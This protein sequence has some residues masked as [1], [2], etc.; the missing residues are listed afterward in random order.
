M[1][2]TISFFHS[3]RGKLILLLLAVSLIPLIIF[4]WISY[5]LARNALEQE[6]FN[7][8]IAVRDIKVR[9]IYERI[10]SWTINVKT[11][12]N[13]PSVIKAAH[14]LHEAIED[15]KAVLGIDKAVDQFRSLYLGQPKLT[16]A[17]DNSAY[18]AAHAQYHH[19]FKE[20]MELHEFSD[21]IMV[22]PHKG[23]I[24]YSVQ[25]GND[26]GNFLTDEVYANSKIGEIFKQAVVSTDHKATFV[27]DFSY[28]ETT[29]QLGLFVASPIIYENEIEAVLIFQLP[30]SQIDIIM[31]EDANLGK[32]GETILV[33]SD[34][35]LLRSN[36]VLFKEDTLLKMNVET[37]ATRASAE[38]ESGL[39]AI[40][41]Y[42]GRHSMIAHTPLDIPGL[43]WSLNAKV[44]KAE[45]LAAADN[46]LKRMLLII[47]IGIVIVVI[48]AIFFSSSIVKPIRGM[49][50]IAGQ[51]ADGNTRLTVDIKKNDEIGQMGQALQQMVTN[52]RE[53]IEDIVRISQALA[54]GN[55]RVKPESEYR[56]DF[57]EIKT[58]LETALYNQREVV[59][60]IVLISQGLASGNL[61]LMP[62]VEYP[63]DFA[64]IK[65]GLENA[66]F[67]L[68]HVVDDI[69]QVSN[70]LAE[71]EHV[72]TKAEYKGEFIQIKNS[73]ETA[74]TKLAEAT[75]NNIIQDWLK[76]GQ[77]QLNEQI[78]GEQDL[79]TLAKNIIHFMPSYLEMPIG[80]F[81]L[82]TGEKAHIL[83]SYAYTK[84]KGLTNEFK[85]GEGLIGQ[86]AMEKKTILVT[87]VP[88]DY[89]HIQSGL[90]ESAPH[91]IIVIPFM[92]ENVVKGVIELGS[93]QKITEVQ[94]ELI[95][96]MMPNIGIAVNTA[97]SRSKMQALLQQNRS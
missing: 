61:R 73:L 10:H 36:S 55:L 46:I 57:V 52:M 82:L 85:L 80:V 96:Q 1:T 40:V 11:L 84:R 31:Q 69:V 29:K 97:E 33:S 86:A 50:N 18:S 60:D 68:Q 22:E 87:S 74:A 32:S 49:I 95:E 54:V 81:Y 44:N 13:N 24:I 91:N 4:G 43:R 8:L 45:A 39:K 12:S 19:M 47:G 72:I 17:G 67:D 21:I 5:D 37:E 89:I 65:Q 83:A 25:K 38:G 62:Q 93:F 79:I 35:F 14:S 59:D 15:Q 77:T 28:S 23:A 3:L 71:G 9:E 70:K 64:Q 20:Y 90:G 48:I 30:A 78:S 76:T 16:N 92:Y 66:L 42:R 26:F 34:D 6:A 63:G 41:D 7:K 58:A 94:L 2:K 56:G 27:V 53:V 88:D 75:Q 51:L